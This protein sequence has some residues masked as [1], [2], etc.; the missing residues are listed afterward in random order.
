MQKCTRGSPCSK[1][2]CPSCT[3]RATNSHVHNLTDN[4]E[5][6]PVKP[7]TPPNH[8]IIRMTKVFEEAIQDQDP[9]ELKMAKDLYQK[10][11]DAVTFEYLDRTEIKQLNRNATPPSSPPSTKVQTS[12]PPRPSNSLKISKLDAPT[13]SG[14]T[15]HL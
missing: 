6:M 8:W 9:S 13:W 10:H 12:V 1:S 5:I 11:L 2:D 7:T 14:E 3:K 15:Y 4:L